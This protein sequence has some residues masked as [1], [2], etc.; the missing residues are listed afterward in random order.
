MDA[1]N[2]DIR[3]FLK[4]TD[5]EEYKNLELESL[6]AAIKREEI[7]LDEAEDENLYEIEVSH[8]TTEQ[9]ISEE[10]P[11]RTV[12]SES[13]S[14]ED[15]LFMI[16]DKRANELKELD[17]EVRGRLNRIFSS[18]ESDSDVNEIGGTIETPSPSKNDVT[19][20]LKLNESSIRSILFL[21]RDSEESEYVK[22]R[23]LRD[24]SANLNLTINLIFDHLNEL[25]IEQ[26][27]SLLLEEENE[28]SYYINIDVLNSLLSNLAS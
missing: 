23:I 19:G 27:N 3:Q 11:K 10:I 6:M 15:D 21:L 16:D 8:E 24:I 2:E 25:A 18:P 22:T 17:E 5:L 12:Q 9:P 20:N 7:V 4:H 28:E 1:N 14:A 26:T 13:I